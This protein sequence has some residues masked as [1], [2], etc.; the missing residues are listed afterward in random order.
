MPNH[1]KITPNSNVVFFRLED[2]ITFLGYSKIES[3]TNEKRGRYTPAEKIA[4]LKEYHEFVP[5]KRAAN[6]IEQE[7]KSLPGYDNQFAIL[8]ITRE[9][10]E[11]IL[12]E[13]EPY[14]IDRLV[15]N[16]MIAYSK[17]EEWEDLLNERKQVIFYG[18]PGKGKTFV[19]IEFS[20]YLIS[21]YGGKHE[22]VQFHPS[23]G[24]E[25]FIEGIKPK[26]TN[27]Q[28]DYQPA[29]G[30]FKILA[31]KARQN[32]TK[33]FILI[34]DEVNRGNLSKIFGELIFSLE[35]RGDANK[36]VLPYTN[37]SFTTPDNLWIIGT[38]NSADRS[39]ALV[40]YALRRR[41]YFIEFMPDAD[42]LYNCLLKERYQPSAVGVDKI[43]LFFVNLNKTILN[44]E[45]LGRHYQL[46]HSYFIKEKLD[47]TKIRRIW[48]YA[49]IPILEEYYFEEPEQITKFEGDAEE[50]LG[51]KLTDIS[52]EGE[53]IS[54][55]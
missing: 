24:Y 13:P 8:P 33:K 29:D 35:Y 49:L 50:I 53:D 27:G 10:F 1:S 2:S 54:K 39:I 34:I 11:M 40:D 46:G 52:G 47:E 19:A 22:I 9:I 16:T 15:E 7:I 38:M 42:I 30:I 37:E 23:Y 36:V 6:R 3:I 4:N 12:S 25:E 5:P 32:P 48:K 43:K 17:Y 55:A 18:P 44:D 20:K 21:K 41:F 51:F 45:K 26:L 14:S 28:L 31:K